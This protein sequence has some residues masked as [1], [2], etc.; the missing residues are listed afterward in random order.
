M[1][2]GDLQ[3]RRRFGATARLFLDSLGLP[4]PNIK[5]TWFTD[6][7]P[8]SEDVYVGGTGDDLLTFVTIAQ[9]R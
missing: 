2:V 5:V 7:S 9:N 8:Q 3:G 1:M 6:L 4:Y